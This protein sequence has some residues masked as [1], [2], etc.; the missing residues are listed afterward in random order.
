MDASKRDVIIMN[1]KEFA[2]PVTDKE[3]ISFLAAGIIRL[4]EK[5]GESEMA[6]VTELALAHW[7][8]VQ[9]PKH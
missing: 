5:M 3:M 8:K 4:Q 1:G 9:S 7:I 2:L 6:E